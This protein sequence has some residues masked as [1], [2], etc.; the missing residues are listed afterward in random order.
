MDGESKPQKKTGIL[1]TNVPD[2]GNV[3]F[4]IWLRLFVPYG[5]GAQWIILDGRRSFLFGFRVFLG[6]LYIT[7]EILK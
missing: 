7:Y 1:Q 2:A 5:N 4:T 3:L 6:L